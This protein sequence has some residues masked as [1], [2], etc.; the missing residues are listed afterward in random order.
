MDKLDLI[1][2]MSVNPGFGGQSFIPHTLEKIAAVRKLIDASGRHILLQVDGGI[3]TD[4]IAEVARAGADTF[5]AGSA[6]FGKPDYAG[7]IA[8]MRSELAK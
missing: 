5:V 6:I 4:N 8:G 3:K 2:L 1:L 7:I